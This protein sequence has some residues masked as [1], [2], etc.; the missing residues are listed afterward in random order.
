MNCPHCH[1]LFDAKQHGATALA[2][3]ILNRPSGI[4]N[5]C[6]VA[7]VCPRCLYWIEIRREFGV[8]PAEEDK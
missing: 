2:K 4:P 7:V 3:S 5:G 8:F 6:C 1:Y